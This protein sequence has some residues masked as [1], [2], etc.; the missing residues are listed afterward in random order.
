MNQ[1][2]ILF[3]FDYELF[4]GPKS[5]SVKNCI[6]IPTQKVVQVLEDFNLIAV[7]FVDCTYLHQLKKV[8]EKNAKAAQDYEEISNQIQSLILNNHEVYPHIHPHWKDAIYHPES[9]NWDLSDLTHYRLDSLEKEEQKT[10]FQVA[11]NC[12]NSI[13][14][15]VKPDY[16]PIA[17][18][19]GGWCIQP[20]SNFSPFFNEFGINS[21]FSVLGGAK[22]D[23]NALKFDFSEIQP[24]ATPYSFSQEVSIPEKNGIYRQYP[25][26]SVSF[27]KRNLPNRILEYILWRTP[28]GQKFGDGQSAQIINKHQETEYDQKMEM[29]SIE[30][31]NLSRLETYK[32]FLRKNQYMQFIS[33]PKMITPHNL[34]V[35]K[36]FLGFTTKRYQVNSDWKKIIMA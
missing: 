31:L 34:S 26:S 2:D 17:F 3:T 24:N 35:L 28:P 33:H 25:I 15:P 7:F 29:V 13:I 8:S 11:L 18:R 23:S 6:I 21:D 30:L 12:L 10:V 32:A 36:K 19:A 9:N 4:L 22:K 14:K 1:K 27:N 20:F 5:G 16:K